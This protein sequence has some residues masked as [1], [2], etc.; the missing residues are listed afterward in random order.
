MGNIV[1]GPVWKP[2]PFGNTDAYSGFVGDAYGYTE[3]ER[4]ASILPINRDGV[5]TVR[6]EQ[7]H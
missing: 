5:T 4:Y 6:P 1:T 3:K 7:S 2:L